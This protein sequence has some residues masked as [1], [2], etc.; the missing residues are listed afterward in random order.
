M[1]RVLAAWL[2]A[3]WCV[4]T[5]APSHAQS[6]ADLAEA[7]DLGQQ[8]LARFD[9]GDFEGAL[10]KLDAAEQKAKIPPLGLYAGRA[11]LRLNRM[12]EA[13]ARFEAVLTIALPPNSPPVWQQ[14][15]DDAKIE[16]DRLRAAIPRVLARWTGAATP[17]FLVDGVSVQGTR[18][19]ADAST[20]VLRV[21]P[22]TREITA[23]SG[24]TTLS[25]KVEAAISTEVPIDF[26]FPSRAAGE[27]TTAPPLLLIG[28]IVLGAGGAGL[29]VWGATGIAAL[30]RADEL[31]CVDA[32]CG[33][34][35]V[36]DLTTL[37]TASTVSF[38][39]GGAL[40]LVGAGLML[41]SLAFP[42]D[43]AERA[44]VVFLGP[45]S[46]GVLGVF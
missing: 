46:V 32:A 8:G 40:T 31:G 36:S 34:Q 13:E 1:R 18:G 41:S 25:R 11:L 5:P 20:V 22:G 15:K 14:A 23:T 6:A 27:E 4:I 26:A 39:V 37:R 43:E 16:L 19:E 30:V 28:G 33:S 38:Y 2:V 17:S 12:L 3:A 29:V 9:A 7:K 21:N 42:T 44:P 35:D 24:E 45:G 10:E